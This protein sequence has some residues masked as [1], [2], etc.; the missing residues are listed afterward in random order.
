MHKK[1]IRLLLMT[2]MMAGVVAM[3]NTSALA[4]TQMGPKDQITKTNQDLKVSKNVKVINPSS[5]IKTTDANYYITGSSDPDEQLFCNGEEVSYRGIFG[6][7]GVYVSLE[8]GKNVFT[9]ENG[10][11]SDSITITRG[12]SQSQGSV[13]TTK[14]ITSMAP[15]YDMAVDSGTTYKLKC[16]APAGAQVWATLNG[17]DYNMTQVAAATKGVPATFVVD[18]K[19]SAKESNST[20]GLGKVEY[21]MKFDGAS[22]VKESVGSI[23]AVGKEASLVVES[24]Q[25]GAIMFSESTTNSSYRGTLRMGSTDKV[26]DQK[27]DMYKLSLGGWVKKDAVSPI[28]GRPQYKVKADKVSFD[29]TSG[30]EEY[31]IDTN[32]GQPSFRAGQD[33]EKITVKFYNTTGIGDVDTSDSK[34]ISSAKVSSEEG[35][36]TVS[37][38]IAD[39]KKAW[40]YNVYYEDGK[41]IIQIK[42]PPKLSGD[43][44]KPLKGITIGIDP[45]HGGTDSGAL[46]VQWLDGPTEATINLA[47]SQSVQNQLEYLGADVVM[48]R[49][50]DEFKSLNER[51]ADGFENNV[52]FFISIHSNSIGLQRNA[53]EVTG[54]EVYYHEGISS[55]FSQIMLA[56]MKENTNFS[57]RRAIQSYYKVTLNSYT[58]SILLELGFITNPK[59]YDRLISQTG[60]YDISVAVA[61]SVIDHLE[62][63]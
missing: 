2:T 40:G 15:S 51:L 54:T 21:G 20:T 13:S 27:G 19:I 36:T 53:N 57:S 26:V 28:A 55:K 30:Y 6:S 34:I 1:N 38:T 29:K 9:F 12:S 18:V 59:D 37:F 8:N 14:N 32:G 63:Y 3:A 60:R 7:F 49:T 10:N 24:V 61:Q 35:D 58:P 50:K 16:V 47:V 17:K 56:N 45:G 62:Q 11:Q 44:S 23:Y 33:N 22:M 42:Y 4:Q 52:D 31:I 41:T 43:E 48:T 5:D 39:G 25:E 46:G